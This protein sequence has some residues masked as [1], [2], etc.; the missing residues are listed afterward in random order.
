MAGAPLGFD[1]LPAKE[2]PSLGRVELRLLFFASF[3]FFSFST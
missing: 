3:Y 1:L 2:N